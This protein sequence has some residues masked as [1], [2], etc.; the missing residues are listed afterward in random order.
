[1]VFV[2]IIMPTVILLTIK[3]KKKLN[4]ISMRSI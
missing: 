4:T 1:M 2:L 3:K